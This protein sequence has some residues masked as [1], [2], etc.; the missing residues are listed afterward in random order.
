MN[1]GAKNGFDFKSVEL[2][3]SN[4]SCKRRR[5]SPHTDL[6][7]D[8]RGLDKSTRINKQE[9]LPKLKFHEILQIAKLSPCLTVSE[10]AFFA[11]VPNTW[12]LIYGSNARSECWASIC[13]SR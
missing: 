8:A 12:W 6:W 1:Q 5:P 3:L 7:L 9:S 4:G 11:S 2:D 13:D 10:T